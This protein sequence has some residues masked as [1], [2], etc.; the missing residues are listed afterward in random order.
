[1]EKQLYYYYYDP[2]PAARCLRV[3]MLSPYCCYFQTKWLPP[4]FHLFHLLHT[5]YIYNHTRGAKRARTPG[6]REAA[7]TGSH[8]ICKWCE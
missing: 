5:E 6:E 4:T 1:M 7:T 8:L 2:S 3:P